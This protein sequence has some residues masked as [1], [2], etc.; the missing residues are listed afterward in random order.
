MP[1]L[2]QARPP[3]LVDAHT[4][5]IFGGWRQNELAMKLRGV[6]YLDILAQGG[7]ILST[8][9]ATRSA[10]QGALEDKARLAL[11]EMLAFGTTTCEAKSGYGLDLDTELT[12]LRAIRALSSPA[13]R[14]PP[15]ASISS[16]WILAARPQRRPA[17]R[18]VL[19]SSAVNTPVSQNTSQNSASPSAATAGIISS[20]SSRMYAARSAL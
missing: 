13:S 18:M 4:H 7:G 8:V 5:L 1:F 11:D 9:R 15:M 12:Q 14:D 19:D 2:A 20:H 6:P 16:A 17:S 3:G 10:G